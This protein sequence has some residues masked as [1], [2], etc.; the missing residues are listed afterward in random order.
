MSQL[1]WITTESGLKLAAQY[2]PV[3]NATWGVL[4]DI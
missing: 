2:S 3:E 4:M 1:V